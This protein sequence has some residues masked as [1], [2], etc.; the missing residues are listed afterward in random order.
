[1]N[2]IV[3]YTT[4]SGVS[5]KHKNYE[6]IVCTEG[7]GTLCCEKY[8]K[9]ISVGEII[10]IPPDTPHNIKSKSSMARIYINGE[11]KRFF[12]LE[13]VSIIRDNEKNEGLILAQMIYENRYANF[14]YVCALTEAFV[15]FL[16]NNIKIDTKIHTCIKEIANKISDKYSDSDLSLS[17][18][19]KESGYSED[20]IREQFKCVTGKT[21][22]EF[23]TTVRITR[24]CYL[25]EIY[26]HSA[27]LTEIS[28]QCGYT[29]Y[30]YFSKKFKQITGVSP[31]KYS[32]T[33][34]TDSHSKF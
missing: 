12:N 33:F 20:Y 6:I 30:V 9:D 16:L 28:E 5:H 22:T 17:Q 7:K 24:A 2:F 31:R 11:F 3:N 34:V 1:M 10:I 15:C 21:P 4:K 32:E 29:D 13:S 23:L 8:K 26:K 18:I 27:T 25:I 19:L 14:E